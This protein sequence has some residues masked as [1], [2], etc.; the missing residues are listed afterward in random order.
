MLEIEHKLLML[1][2]P[3]EAALEQ[4]AERVE[5][6]EQ[7]YL[8]AEPGRTRRIRRVRDADGERLILTEKQPVR[9]GV[10][11]EDETLLDPESYTRLA[12]D[13]DPATQP[14]RKT[15]YI[16]TIPGAATLVVDVFSQP[17]GLTL[18]EV[19]L[20]TEDTAYELPG[21]LG[22][23]RDVT[24]DERYQNAAIARGGVPPPERSDR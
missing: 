19:E 16:T 23:T 3:S 9:S 11:V 5:R 2:P 24:D 14:I 13:V 4:R 17:P 20:P 22:P 8:T 6:I 18:A 21:W 7:R 1:D 10:R 15:R 12:A